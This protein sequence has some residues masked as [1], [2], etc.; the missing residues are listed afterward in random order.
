MTVCVRV[1]V[2]V[3]IPPSTYICIGIYLY[4]MWHSRQNTGF[5]Y[6]FESKIYY[7]LCI[8]FGQII[9]IF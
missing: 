9:S 5:G 1:C 2:C 6:K 3:H 7:L 4:E 8:Q